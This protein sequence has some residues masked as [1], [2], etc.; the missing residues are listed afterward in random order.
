MIIIWSIGRRFNKDGRISLA[1]F[2][3]FDRG[4]IEKYAFSS[5]YYFGK[6][7]KISTWRVNGLCIHL[8]RMVLRQRGRALSTA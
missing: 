1:I 7:E 6:S 2:V 5:G 3:G 4:M 8:L